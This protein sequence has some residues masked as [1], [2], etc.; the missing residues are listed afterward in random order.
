M[1]Q[2]D[3]GDMDIE[4]IWKNCF[5]H[6]DISGSN[7]IQNINPLTKDGKGTLTVFSKTEEIQQHFPE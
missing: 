1:H 4:L 5:L 6:D 2:S 3:L 7:S